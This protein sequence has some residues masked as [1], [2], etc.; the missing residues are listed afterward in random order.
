MVPKLSFFVA[1][2]FISL[3]AAGP[4]DTETAANYECPSPY[5][6][7]GPDNYCLLIDNRISGTWDDM[8]KFCKEWNGDL[9]YFHDANLLYEVVHYI[10]QH[11]LND[12]SFW[13]GAEDIEKEG[14]WVWANDHTSVRMHTPL[15]APSRYQQEP[16]GG[17]N[18]NCAALNRDKH[19]FLDDGYCEDRNGVICDP[20]VHQ[21]RKSEE[22]PVEAV[23]EETAAS[24]CPVPFQMIS[25]ACLLISVVKTN[26][27]FDSKTLCEALG[28]H[29]A[30]VDDANLMGDLYDYLT[31]KSVR[32]PLWIGDVTTV[33]RTCHLPLNP[34]SSSHCPRRCPHSFM[35][36]WRHYSHEAQPPSS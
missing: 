3:A 13:T 8:R 14:D 19:F 24:E 32:T 23:E 4:T 36:R 9:A 35:A 21:N 5:Q 12:S 28:G 2:T 18:Q 20:L 34:N 30:K 29:L 31:N 25:D 22:T 16:A 17:I 7:V 11:D 27:W 10:H 15:W 6:P 33:T 26:T 1:L